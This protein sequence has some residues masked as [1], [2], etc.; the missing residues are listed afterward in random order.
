M[1]MLMM[2]RLWVVLAALLACST[3]FA[4]PA[5]AVEKGKVAPSS[6]I[7]TFDGTNHVYSIVGPNSGSFT[8]EIEVQ[9]SIP[10]PSGCSAT[11]ARPAMQ[12]CKTSLSSGNPIRLSTSTLI[13]GFDGTNRTFTTNIPLNSGTDV[14]VTNDLATWTSV[15][16]EGSP[17]CP[18]GTGHPMIAHGY[19]SARWGDNSLVSYDRRSN[20]SNA[21]FC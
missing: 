1:E 12:L 11:A 14:C 7:I 21:R 4:V 19:G 18:V 13:I 6:A 10:C 16:R 15:I 17:G 5:Q 3:L 8:F 9:F 20:P 2:K